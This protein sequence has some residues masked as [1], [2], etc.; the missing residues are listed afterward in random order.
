MENERNKSKQMSSDSLTHSNPYLFSWIAVTEYRFFDAIT[1]I[2]GYKRKQ[3][4]RPIL[5]EIVQFVCRQ[6]HKRL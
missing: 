3:L 6:T 1:T 5:Q 4:S 2:N